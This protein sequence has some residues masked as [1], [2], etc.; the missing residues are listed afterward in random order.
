MARNGSRLRSGLFGSLAALCLSLSAAPAFTAPLADA[1]CKQR[2]LAASAKFL[3]KTLQC[4]A[5]QAAEGGSV[6]PT[7]N[8]KALQ[9]FEH[10]YQK[11]ELPNGCPSVGDLAKA[12]S[13]TYEFVAE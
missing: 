8:A 1:R 5:Q 7:C 9:R 13:L 12:R 2:K 6:S 11:A 4:E 3:K 10:Y